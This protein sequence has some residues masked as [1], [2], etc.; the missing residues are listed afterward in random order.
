MRLWREWAC[1]R[2]DIMLH[3]LTIRCRLSQNGGTWAWKL[4]GGALYLYSKQLAA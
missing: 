2:G 1:V 3:G 4:T